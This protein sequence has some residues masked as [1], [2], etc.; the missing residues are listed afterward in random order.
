MATEFSQLVY[1]SHDQGNVNTEENH[2]FANIVAII[3]VRI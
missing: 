2:F 3:A 1:S